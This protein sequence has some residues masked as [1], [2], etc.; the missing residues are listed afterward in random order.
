MSYRKCYIVDNREEEFNDDN[1]FKP[2]GRLI[3]SP[4]KTREYLEYLKKMVDS[5]KNNFRQIMHIKLN[6][7]YLKK[8]LLAEKNKTADWLDQLRPNMLLKNK[9]LRNKLL[10]DKLST[11]LPIEDELLDSFLEKILLKNKYF[12]E[13]KKMDSIK[14]S[15]LRKTLSEV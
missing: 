10:E 14:D 9:L 4:L 11:D 6:E 13:C 3:Y 12:D 15:L 1:Y 7:L 2:K 8:K 5:P